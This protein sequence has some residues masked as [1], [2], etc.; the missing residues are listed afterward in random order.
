MKN[1]SSAKLLIAMSLLGTSPLFA[2]SNWNITTGG[3]WDIAANWSTDPVIPNAIDAD[4]RITNLLTTGA[5]TVNATAPTTFTVGRLDLGATSVGTDLDVTLGANVTLNFATSVDSAQLNLATGDTGSTLIINSPIQLSSPLTVTR[6]RTGS[7]QPIPVF[8][9]AINLQSHTFTVEASTGGFQF[10]GLISGTG[11]IGLS[12][13]QLSPRNSIF[14]NPANTFSGGITLGSGNILQLG[15]VGTSYSGSATNGIAGTG[16]ISI[17]NSIF[18]SASAAT[19]QSTGAFVTNDFIDSTTNVLGNAINVPAGEFLRIDTPRPINLGDGSG[20]LS[21]EGHII[22]V[23]GNTGGQRQVILGYAN[24]GFTGIF[25]V[26]DGQ[27]HTRASD[28][29]AAGATLRF[30][31]Q[32]NTNRVGLMG[33]MTSGGATITIPAALD[34]AKNGF[35]FFI[36]T[37]G[38]STF[39]L[40]GNF[41]NSDAG[42]DAGLVGV[43]R[44]DSFSADGTANLTGWSTGT[45]TGLATIALAGTG[46]L[47]NPIS[48]RNGTGTIS[49]LSLRNTTGTQIFSG[50]ITSTGRLVRDGVGG[51][52]LL[53]GANTYA[54]TTTVTSGALFVNGTHIGGG[55]YSVTGTLGGSGT[56]TPGATATLIVNS[57]GDLAPGAAPGQIGTLTLDGVNATGTLATLV[58]GAKLTLDLDGTLNTGDR[59][60]IA[61]GSA[62]DLVFNN[63]VVEFTPVGV[64]SAGQTY[65]LISASAADNFSGLTLDGTNKITGGLSI[66]APLSGFGPSYLSVAGADIVLTLVAD[67]TGDALTAFRTANSLA[68]DGSQDLLTPAGDGV[69][70]LLKY[71]F[72]MIGAGAG[73]AATLTTA[74]AAVLAPGGSAGLPL[75]GVESGTGK[76]TITYIRRIAT[77]TPAPGIS[78]QVQFNS[79]LTVPSGW[80]ANPAATESVTAINA[81]FERVIITDS[82]AATPRRFARVQVSIP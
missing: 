13:S 48:I 75:V 16:P 26:R 19:I 30:N 47:E 70:N 35:P 55:N 7:H 63:N 15:V 31:P 45:N 36:T 61:N 66:G 25:E 77:A 51:I 56:L 39:L 57:G 33:G 43:G 32:N 72:N 9:G 46:T 4:A 24:P 42:G 74:N 28:A 69:S 81:D 40:T 54:G 44:G 21:G 62:S 82:A 38:D 71:A 65:T 64:F 41:S 59:L 67:V 53:N 12:T 49:V 29:L 73:Q 3:D 50:N 76:L 68:S 5:Y 79:D 52:S 14:T 20:D 34:F 2:Q 27:L 23:F 18:D 78:Y 10:S 58:T 6:T 22:K 17:T 60:T 8:N 37:S 80:A 1:T 11:G